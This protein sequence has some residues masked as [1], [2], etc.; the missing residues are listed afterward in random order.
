[1]KYYPCIFRTRADL[2]ASLAGESMS[3]DSE[4]YLVVQ[5]DGLDV[6]RLEVAAEPMSERPERHA[7]DVDSPKES[8]VLV[9]AH[10]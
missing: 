7:G 9:A 3:V 10:L 8:E 2:D 6:R 1:M 4:G 5:R